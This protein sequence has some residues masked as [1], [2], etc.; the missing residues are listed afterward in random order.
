M[1]QSERF[2][3]SV[4]VL[5]VLAEQPGGMKTSA[6]IAESLKESAVMVRRAFLLLHKAGLIEQR[7]GPRGGARLKL[8]PKQI[9]LG[10]VFAATS[11][12]WLAIEDKAIAGL[13]KKVRDDAVEAMNEHSLAGVVKRMKKGSK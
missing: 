12:E 10:D 4:R 7:K 3:L 8:Q 2:Q 9:G 13:M 5:T 1:A 6:E 11:G